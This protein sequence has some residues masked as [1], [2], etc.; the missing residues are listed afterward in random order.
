VSDVEVR[1]T[2]AEAVTWEELRDTI[3]HGSVPG[4]AALLSATPPELLKHLVGDIKALYRQTN[5][6]LRA[7]DDSWSTMGDRPARIVVAAVMCEQTP[8]QVA[9]WIRRRDLPFTL[10]RR[11]PWGS[12]DRSQEG[13]IGEVLVARRDDAWLAELAARLTEALTSPMVR[14]QLFGLIMQLVAVSGA[15]VPLTDGYVLAWLAENPVLRTEPRLRELVARI[16][17]VPGAAEFLSTWSSI[18]ETLAELT[19]EGVLD[20]AAMLDG[21]TAKLLRDDTIGNLRGFHRLHDAIDPTA[22]EVGARL[23]TYLGMIASSHSATAKRAQAALKA[24]DADK[25]LESATLAELSV[26]VFTRPE[27]NLATT[28]LAWIGA[29]IGR[30]P[31]A[32]PE[33]LSTLTTAFGHRAIA[34]QQRA[35]RFAAKHLKP[36]RTS[37]TVVVDDELRSRLREAAGLLDPVLAPEARA[38]FGAGPDE[39]AAS[40]STSAP[41]SAPEVDAPQAYQ[42]P[43]RS[44]PIDSVEELAEAFAPVLAQYD[45]DVAQAERIMAAV[46]RFAHHDRSAFTALAPLAARYPALEGSSL[47]WARWQVPGAL[48][49]LF[50]AALDRTPLPRGTTGELASWRPG[51]AKVMLVRIYELADAIV[52]DRPAPCLLAT[53]T[54]SNGAI[55]PQAFLDRLAEYHACAAEPMRRDLEQALVRLP[56]DPGPAVRAALAGL[57]PLPGTFP[58][59]AGFYIRRREDEIAYDPYRETILPA[60]PR[61]ARFAD[62]VGIHTKARPGLSVYHDL[63]PERS[64]ADFHGASAPEVPAGDWPLLLPHHPDVVAAHAMRLLLAE[65]MDTARIPSVFPQLAETAGIP[66]PVAH[67]ALAYGMVARTPENRIAA[68]DGLLILA[69]RGLLDPATLGLHIGQLLGAGMIKPNRLIP[70]LDDAARGGAAREIVAVA[71]AAIAELADV[72]QARGLPDL[73]LLA[74]RYAGQAGGPPVAFPRLD[75]LAALAKPARVAQE[76]KRLSLIL[77]QS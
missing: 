66:G 36:N 26:A 45:A 27:A 39:T 73:L 72:P 10:L 29:A 3:V 52:T 40:A 17:E 65:A 35:L 53:P 41:G 67:A 59:F 51:A 43:P 46:A 50:L 22:D 55:D 34:V 11:A 69:A 13:L 12:L 71:A 64:F 16:F 21:C 14:W 44:V 70:S 68:V 30:D 75:E 48:Q 4:V 8:A 2:V 33:L 37:K 62:R 77:R 38:V 25:P 28:Q 49:L 61:A 6:E 63:L 60:P 58:D 5:A 19:A 47:S 18:P 1:T 56:P 20:R 42:P 23:P 24:L 7:S 32:A 54:E 76:A 31:A 57:R 74:A 15:Q 9:W